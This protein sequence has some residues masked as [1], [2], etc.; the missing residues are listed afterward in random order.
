MAEYRQMVETHLKDIDIGYLALNAGIGNGGLFVKE[1][2]Q[3]VEDVM[4]LNGL[5]VVYLCK[6]LLTKML[7]RPVRS[8]IIIT[9]S[10]M[11]SMGPPFCSL[12]A[13]TKAAERLF[14]ESLHYELRHKIDVLTFMPAYTNTKI[15][16]DAKGN[17]RTSPFMIEPEV[18][19]KAM[20]KDLG[21]CSES[22]GS[23]KHSFLYFCI[24]YLIPRDFGLKQMSKDIGKR[25]MKVY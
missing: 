11:S 17:R 16:D 7:A 1:T 5:H 3:M 21:R 2:D 15:L 19:V 25:E 24:N 22:C 14:G 10:V 18:A 8:A 13:A 4:V 12:Y 9:S 23:I 6:A 20:H